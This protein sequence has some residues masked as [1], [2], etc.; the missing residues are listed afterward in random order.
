MLL[1]DLC[2]TIID[3]RGKTPPLSEYGYA[4]IEAQCFSSQN[5][6]KS[7]DAVKHITKSTFLNMRGGTC[8]ENDI[9]VTLVGN[10]GHCA[11]VLE[12]VAI[13]QN[14]VALRI[15]TRVANPLYVFYYMKTDYFKKNCEQLNRSSVQPSINVNDFL[16]IEI[17][18]PDR[19]TQDKIVDIL[20]GIDN[21]IERNNDMVKKL[22]V[23]GQAIFAQHFAH[24]SNQCSLMEF[25][26][27]S[28]I[29]PGI[30]PFDSGKRYLTTS[31]VNNSD[32]NWDA[33]TVQFSTR[34]NRANMEPQVHSVWFAKLKNS[35]K[36]I[37]IPA[38]S[39][40]LNNYILSTGFCGLLCDDTAF[41][42][43][44]AL[45]T[46]PSFESL[47]DKFA[48]G[49][50]MEAVNND[51]LSCFVIPNPDFNTLES[52]HLATQGL[53]QQITDI[54]YSSYKLACMRNSLLPMLINGQITV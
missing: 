5:F 28:V 29:K 10:I 27:I 39:A 32:I 46:H 20:F 45:I 19:K 31:D 2:E 50:T 15:D 8:K 16:N 18:L 33:S 21:Q 41:E 49:A 12:P 42:F 44:S 23:L 38:R 6:V 34:E 30:K 9:V 43:M 1:K 53:Y 25:P 47:K 26:Y 4:L 7:E 13:A 24:C 14:I 54:Q 36:H 35:V 17:D 22:Q 52:F 3:N 51:D 37:C 11:L 48:H 40:L